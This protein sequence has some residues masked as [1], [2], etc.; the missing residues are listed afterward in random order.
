[1]TKDLFISS[2]TALKTQFEKDEKCVEA[3]D[4][5]LPYDNISGYDNSVLIDAFINLLKECVNDTNDWIDYFVWELDFG[6]DY[7]DGCVRI[8]GKD[9]PLRTAEDLWNIINVNQ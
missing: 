6:R 7:T 1:M 3:F 4:V 9:V 2:V 5:I 8:N